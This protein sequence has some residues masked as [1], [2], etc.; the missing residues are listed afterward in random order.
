[1]VVD[2]VNG[3]GVEQFLQTSSIS[4][5][6]RFKKG[7]GR[8]GGWETSGPGELQ[9]AVVSYRKS[10]LWSLLNPFLQ[11]DL[12]STIHIANKSKLSCLAGTGENGTSYLSL[13]FS[14]KVLQ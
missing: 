3:R 13:N 11:V 5:F 9:T 7:E 1:M 12:V 10:F 2:D 8:V 4:D 14:F 6:M